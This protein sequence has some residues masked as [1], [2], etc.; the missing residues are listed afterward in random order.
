MATRRRSTADG[1]CLLRQSASFTLAAEI[2][3]L[4]FAALLFGL[5]VAP[6]SWVFFAGLPGAVVVALLIHHG[7]TTARLVA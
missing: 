3:L 5:A 1:A 4:P 6:V 7:V 2:L